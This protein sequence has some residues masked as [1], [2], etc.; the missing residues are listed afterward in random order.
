MNKIGLT[1]GKYAPLHKGHQYVIE[2]ALKEMDELFVI[3]YDTPLI[4]IPLSVRAGWIK[5]LYPKVK[6]IEARNSPSENMPLAEYEKAEEEF[7]KK[8]LN[9][10][11]ITHFYCSEYY[12]GHISRALNA[13]DRRVDENRETVPIAATKIRENLFGNR[14][15]ISEVVY[16]DLIQKIVFMGAPSTGK[17]TLASALAKDLNTVWMPE[18]GREYWTE[19]QV[20]RRIGLEEFITIAKTHMEREDSLIMEANKYFFV[21]TNAITTYM[22]SLDYHGKALPE[23][24]QLARQCQSRYDLFFL[25]ED[26]IP[27]DDTWDRSG[28]Q[29][30]GVFHRQ[31]IADLEKR[32]IPFIR[33][34]GSLKQRMDAVKSYLRT[35]PLFHKE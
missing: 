9:G 10:Q 3:I 18:Y 11:P 24:S 12:G 27:Y 5:T 7:I 34:R 6:V 8:L 23:M 30:R 4:S 29:K 13:V 20:N 21:D 17:T 15:F 32:Q 19:H 35:E 28:E 33:L 2:T 22:F 25:C 14:Q 1:L 16:R 26:D 31:I